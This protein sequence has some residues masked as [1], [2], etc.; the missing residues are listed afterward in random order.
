LRVPRRGS[1]DAWMKLRKA[2]VWVF[3]SGQISWAVGCS[4]SE[5]AQ[6]A[7]GADHSKAAAPA[8]ACGHAVCADDFLVDVTVPQGCSVGTLCSATLQL[9][10]KGD[11]HI[12]DDY[13]YRFNANETAGVRFEGTQAAARNVFS[14]PS[15]DW[16][17][18]NAKSGEMKIR[19]TPLERGAKTIA[20]IFK[21]SVCSEGACLVEQ[22]RVLASVAVN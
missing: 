3:V 8:A 6:P 13:P 19:F 16:Q 4:R 18:T 15:G 20:G 10:A 22:P 14:K 9:V 1:T 12:N 2:L 5:A 7:G 11:F 17:K 21:L